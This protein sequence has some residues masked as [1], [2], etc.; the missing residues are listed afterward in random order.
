VLLQSTRHVIR[1]SGVERAICTPQEIDEPTS[2]RLGSDSFRRRLLPLPLPC[3][4]LPETLD[5]MIVDHPHRLHEGV[6]D[7]TAD[8]LETAPFTV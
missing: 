1:D 2:V 7:R 6:A 3:F 5:Q 4:P 8:E